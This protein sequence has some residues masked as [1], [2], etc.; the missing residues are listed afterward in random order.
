M[1][2]GRRCA[3]AW[4]CRCP[5]ETPCAFHSRR[6][7]FRF[8]DSQQLMVPGRPRGKSQVVL[9]PA[10][11]SNPGS[12][13]N[14]RAVAPAFAPGSTRPH[15]RRGRRIPDTCASDRRSSDL[16][17]QSVLLVLISA[18]SETG[19]IPGHI[20]VGPGFQTA[21]DSRIRSTFET[22]QRRNRGGEDGVQFSA[23]R[24]Q[25]ESIAAA[26]RSPWS[27]RNSK[28]AFLDAR[29]LADLVDG[30]GAVGTAQMSSPTVINRSLASLTRPI[31]MFQSISCGFTPITDQSTML[32]Y[33]VNYFLATAVVPSRSSHAG[34]RQRRWSRRSRRGL[35]LV[36]VP[37]SA[38]A[39]SSSSSSPDSSRRW[40]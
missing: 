22:F 6:H 7:Q 24:C 18:P 39:C 13:R 26:A 17:L 5:L 30:R 21:G 28:T 10:S 29:F 33:M 25:Y 11:V 4:L 8:A 3:P 38:S 14:M 2:L 32:Y 9:D 34:A 19:G 12:R 27:Q 20:R 36:R 40:S 16:L 15:G 23:R 35:R 31:T 37:C 1:S